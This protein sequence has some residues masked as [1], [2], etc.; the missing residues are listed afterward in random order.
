ML[1]PGGV[2]VAHKEG[3]IVGVSDDVGIVFSRHPYVLCI[4]SEGQKDVEAGF[5]KIAEVSRMV[6]DYQ[7]YVYGCTPTGALIPCAWSSASFPS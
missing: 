2:Q 6:F 5:R 4:L 1:L 3:D 7:E